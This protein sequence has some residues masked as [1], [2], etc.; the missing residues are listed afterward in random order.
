MCAVPLLFTWVVLTWADIPADIRTVSTREG[1]D[2][3]LPCGLDSPVNLE[4]E[5]FDWKR[6][7]QEVFFYDMGKH[8]NNNGRGGQD[9]Q[10]VG[11]VRL[12]PGGLRT[13][14]ASVILS[15]P[16]EEDSGVY[17]CIF[18][19]LGLTRRIRLIVVVE[20]RLRLEI[21]EAPLSSGWARLCCVSR[22][23]Q[24]QPRGLE[25]QTQDGNV[26]PAEGAPTAAADVKG[27]HS[28]SQCVKVTEPGIYT[29]LV[30]QEGVHPAVRDTIQVFALSAAQVLRMLA[31]RHPAEADRISPGC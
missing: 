8:Y 5:V 1:E 31:G 20:P 28:I 7:E 14:N 15:D 18:P 2:A 25:W 21:K 24:P 27:H 4:Q 30:R 13:G 26:I 23:G 22:G 12:L 6:D 9:P 17:K 10:F 29:C 19:H 11:R 16:T 3:I